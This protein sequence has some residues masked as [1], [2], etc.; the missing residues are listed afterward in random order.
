MRGAGILGTANEI[1]N[2]SRAVMTAAP[3]GQK[4]SYGCFI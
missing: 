4:E 1:R 3:A 2:A